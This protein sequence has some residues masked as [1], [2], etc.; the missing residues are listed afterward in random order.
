M[1]N[2]DV[3]QTICLR[4]TCQEVSK[5]SIDWRD[6]LGCYVKKKNNEK[7]KF[8]ESL[9]MYEYFKIHEYLDNREYFEIYESF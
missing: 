1:Y 7:L 5:A 2:I 9:E 4:D 6:H 8:Y 3:K